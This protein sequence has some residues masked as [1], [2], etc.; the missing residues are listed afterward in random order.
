MGGVTF[1]GGPGN[2]V[3]AAVVI[4]GAADHLQGVAAEYG[5][6]TSEFGRR[7]VDWQLE[8]QALLKVGGR[9]YDEMRLRLADGTRQMVYFDLS[10]FF[11]RF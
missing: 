9:Y 1:E 10:E 6:L 4:R 3:E 7:G 2:T 8:Q 5:Y 11:G